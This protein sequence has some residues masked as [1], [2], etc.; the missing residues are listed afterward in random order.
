MDEWHDPVSTIPIT[1]IRRQKRQTTYRS[2]FEMS[3][4]FATT[5]QLCCV[6]FDFMD[7]GRQKII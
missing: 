3:A 2:A 7:E 1:M 6:Y 4:R 5:Q